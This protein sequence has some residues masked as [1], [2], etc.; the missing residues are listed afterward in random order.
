MKRRLCAASRC[1]ALLPRGAEAHG[2][3]GA[4]VFPMTLTVDDP[5]VSDEASLPTFSVQ[6]Q[7]AGDDLGPTWQYNLSGEFDKRITENFGVGVSTAYTIQSTEGDKTRTGFLNPTH[8]AVVSV[9]M[10]REFER[11]GID[12]RLVFRDRVQIVELAWSS[13]ASKPTDLGTQLVFAPGLIYSAE[14]YQLGL[15]ALIPANR[16]F[17]RNL[18]VI[19]QFHLFFDDLFPNSLGKPLRRRRGRHA[20][21]QAGRSYRTGRR[22]APRRRLGARDTG[23]LY[24]HPARNVGRHA[25]NRGFV[26]VHRG[27]VTR[28]R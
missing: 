25:Q 17:G 26:Q 21:R 15:E 24:G 7:G 14:T 22:K 20:D 4:R 13:H 27:A 8:E 1:A 18:G 19:T 23:R 28:A 3:A 10:I 6:R 9:G 5:G 11:T 2:I 12:P 16:A